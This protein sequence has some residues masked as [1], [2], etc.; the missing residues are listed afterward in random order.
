VVDSSMDDTP[1]IV[2]QRFVQVTLVHR[3]QQNFAAEA[4]NIGIEHASGGMVA[5]MDA[6]CVA[7]SG[8]IDAIVASQ[9]QKYPA[10]G[11]AINLDSTTTIAGA[12]LFGIDLSESGAGSPRR[13]IRRLPSC[14]L[15]VKRAS[16]E[17]YGSFPTEIQA[18]EDILF[19]RRLMERSGARVWFNPQM[20]IRHGN[21]NILAE[22]RDKLV[23]LGC[24]SGR[25][26][27]SG[28]LPDAVAKASSG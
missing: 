23:T 26:R 3:Q 12:T 18:S 28:L 20:R 9:R 8:W 4:R 16:L 2:S 6:D 11:G 25:S 21:R 10:V 22:L 7:D 5:F 27:A 13:R 24:W 1:N 19:T 15:A 17:A 14:N